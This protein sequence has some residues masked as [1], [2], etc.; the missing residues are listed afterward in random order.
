MYPLCAVSERP[1]VQHLEITFF[2]MSILMRSALDVLLQPAAVNWNKIIL[3]NNH[4]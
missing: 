4:I 3:F 2:T 1:F